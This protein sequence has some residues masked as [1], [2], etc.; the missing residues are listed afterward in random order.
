[1]RPTLRCPIPPRRKFFF[2]TLPA[3]NPWILFLSRIHEKKG[4]D[5]L[6]DAVALLPDKQPHLVIAGDGD[7]AYVAAMKARAQNAGIGSRTHFVGLVRGA[8]KTAL[9]RRAAMLALPS[10]QENFGI[11]FAEALACETTVLVT[12]G[13]DIHEELTASGGALLIRREPADIAEKIMALL[14]DPPAARAR[15]EAGRRWVFSALDPKTITGQWID[16]YQGL[17]SRV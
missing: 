8:A 10:S 15:G 7:A 16:A 14:A 12:Q 3:G 9:F 4:L 1:M 2:S 5:L 6:I 17:A 11:V 13:V